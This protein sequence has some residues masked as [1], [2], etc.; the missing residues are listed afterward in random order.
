MSRRRLFGPPRRNPRARLFKECGAC[1]SPPQLLTLAVPDDNDFFDWRTL[2][3]TCSRG[4]PGSAICVQRLDDSLNSA[5]HTT[6]RSLLRSSSMHEPRDPP[7]EVVKVFRQN[8]ITN[9]TKFH[10]RSRKKPKTGEIGSRPG[11][12]WPSRFP[13]IR[14]PHPTECRRHTSNEPNGLS[15]LRLPVHGVLP[16]RARR[17]RLGFVNDPSAGS[18][19]ETLLRL[20]LPLNNSVSSTF[21]VSKVASPSPRTPIR[22][23]H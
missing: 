21:R 4:D 12:R 13:P 8:K 20:L 17:R 19:T 14:V 23:S 3:Q 6:Y 16:S 10:K 2:E 5:I 7:S 18:P 9:T 15:P 11:G 1:R 22:R